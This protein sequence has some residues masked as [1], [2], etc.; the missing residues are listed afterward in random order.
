M[1]GWEIRK[2]PYIDNQRYLAKDQIMKKFLAGLAVI[3]MN[4]LGMN[5]LENSNRNGTNPEYALTP[6]S[7]PRSDAGSLSADQLLWC[8]IFELEQHVTNLKE[9]N[10]QK[11]LENLRLNQ[12]NQELIASG[13]VLNTSSKNLLDQTKLQA[14]I[15][16]L[17]NSI[18]RTKLKC[19]Y[20]GAA[21]SEL[22]NSILRLL[23]ENQRLVSN[24]E[25]LSRQNDRLL[26]VI[27][28]SE[29]QKFS[30]SGQN[31]RLQSENRHLLSNN[32]SL[33]RQ[34]ERLRSE[35][36]RLVSD[37]ESLNGQNAQLRSENQRSS[38]NIQ[39][40]LRQNEQKDQFIS[41]LNKQNRKLNGSLISVRRIFGNIAKQTLRKGSVRITK[42]ALEDFVI[43]A[44]NSSNKTNVTINELFGRNTAEGAVMLSNPLNLRSSA[45]RAAPEEAST[46]QPSAHRR[47]IAPEAA[48]SSASHLQQPA[49]HQPANHQEETNL[50]NDVEKINQNL[51]NAI[52]LNYWGGTSLNSEK[53]ARLFSY[54]TDPNYEGGIMK[55]YL[56]CAA[57]AVG[58]W[59]AVTDN[60]REYL[61]ILA[62]NIHEA[63]E[64]FPVRDRE[65]MNELETAV[66]ADKNILPGENL[67]IVV[68]TGNKEYDL[69]EFVNDVRSRESDMQAARFYPHAE[70]I[71]PLVIALAQTNWPALP[72]FAAEEELNSFEQSVKSFVDE[73]N[74]RKSELENSNDPDRNK[75]LKTNLV[76]TVRNLR[77]FGIGDCLI[78]NKLNLFSSN[79]ENEAIQK[80]KSMHPCLKKGNPFNAARRKA[81]GAL[82]RQG[83]SNKEIA[84]MLGMSHSH[85]CEVWKD[86]NSH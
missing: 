19:E 38:I 56:G 48:S 8:R 21:I 84:A 70:R 83:K 14:A 31:E 34:N 10:K 26:S 62:R 82:K 58:I 75:L 46:S 79:D 1:G 9:Q 7:S 20:T 60:E 12:K 71:K 73:Y 33:S 24:N 80:F 40:L 11:D 77:K 69:I 32:K 41:E 39:Q 81:V 44:F 4:V 51:V 22:N 54:L 66:R 63:P 57:A 78:A 52:T 47:R 49:N 3:S 55:A 50:Q 25:S 65:R 42:S 61:S 35:N 18:L 74:R 72:C 2:S 27:W 16:E 28:N 86:I 23:S 6:D 36:Q 76:N 17:N 67:K 85:V 64:R 5:P 43:R 45:K 53:C 29:S 68:N 13:F 30:L 37:N 59:N 15:S